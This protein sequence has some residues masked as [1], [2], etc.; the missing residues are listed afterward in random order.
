MVTLGLLKQGLEPNLKV[1]I[2]PR[3]ILMLGRVPIRARHCTAEVV[4]G[5]H[6]RQADGQNCVPCST[7]MKI[8]RNKIHFHT[9]KVR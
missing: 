6:V 4:D 7:P 9:H 1:L 2:N 3:M 8:L 5:A